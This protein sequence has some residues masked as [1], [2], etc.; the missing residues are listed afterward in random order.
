MIIL[1]YLLD[2]LLKIFSSE[3]DMISWFYFE[4]PMVIIFFKIEQS[5]VHVVK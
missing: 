4:C 2:F 1:T 3:S 5:I